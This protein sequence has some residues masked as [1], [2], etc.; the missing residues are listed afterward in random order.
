MLHS[1]WESAGKSVNL[2]DWLEGF[3]MTLLDGKA[4]GG[5]EEVK[6]TEPTTPSK[7]KRRREEALEGEEDTAELDEE[8]DARAHARF[9]R[10][11]EEARM[12]GLVRMRGKK[13]DEVLK[14]VL[15]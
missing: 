11:V 13:G 2:W 7:G 1:L 6:G 15:L 10:F 14:A 8:E 12:M 4:K 3:R 5:E 9:I